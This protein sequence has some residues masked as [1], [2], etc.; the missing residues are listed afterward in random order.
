MYIPNYISDPNWLPAVIGKTTGLVS[1]TAVLCGGS[2]KIVRQ[3]SDQIL[4]R[5]NKQPE[6]NFVDFGNQGFKFSKENVN[7]TLR[8]IILSETVEIGERPTQS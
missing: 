8:E 1:Y 2:G 3:H 4:G 5:S 6:S 7:P